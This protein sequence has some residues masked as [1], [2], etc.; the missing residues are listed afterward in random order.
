MSLI[1]RC[2]ACGTM[3]NVVTDQLKVSQGWVRCGHCAEVFDASLHMQATPTP[4]TLPQTPQQIPQ[5]TSQLQ[6]FSE[7]EF[8]PAPLAADP[9]Y[10]SYAEEISAALK[11]PENI[12][13]KQALDANANLAAS[14]TLDDRRFRNILCFRLGKHRQTPDVKRISCCQIDRKSVV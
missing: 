12:A 3:F 9:S 14:Y 13:G 4:Q 11:T 1:T 5:Q 8:K 7:P 10:F 2:P 6:P